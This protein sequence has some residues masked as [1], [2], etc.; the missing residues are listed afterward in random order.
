MEKEFYAF[1]FLNKSQSRFDSSTW[2]V[3]TIY[4][5]FPTEEEIINHT[6]LKN[7]PFDRELAKKLVE[8][9]G[10]P[11][12]LV[13]SKDESTWYKK[14]F[15]VMITTFRY[16]EEL[17]LEDFLTTGYALYSNEDKIVFFKK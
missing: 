3:S 2:R 17:K 5:H 12:R 16:G 15:E 1:C 4:N 13:Y 8:G 6:C 9:N 7:T 14:F 11:V 10:N